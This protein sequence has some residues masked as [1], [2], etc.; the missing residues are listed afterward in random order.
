M[1]ELAEA[2]TTTTTGCCAPDLAPRLDTE[3][4]Q[5]LGADLSIL[6]QPIRLQILDMGC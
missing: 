2:A 3:A 5:R 4:A 6:G 1:I